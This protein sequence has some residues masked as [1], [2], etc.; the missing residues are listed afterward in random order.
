MS[1]IWIDTVTVEEIRVHRT[2]RHC[3]GLVMGIA[4]VYVYAF[5]AT[6]VTR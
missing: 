2:T 4:V 5:A 3:Y 1:N 6:A